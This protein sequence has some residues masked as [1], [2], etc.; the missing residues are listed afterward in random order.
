MCS[1]DSEFSL[2]TLNNVLTPTENTCISYEMTK[3]RLK[4]Q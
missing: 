3:L 4:Q 1:L 2:Q